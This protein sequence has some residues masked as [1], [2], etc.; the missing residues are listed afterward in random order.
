MSRTLLVTGAAGFI[1][2]CFTELAISQGHKVIALDALTYAGQ[3]SNLAH[4]EDSNL[5]EFVHGN[6]CSA[7]LVEELF[8]TYRPDAV[9]NLAA[10]SHVDRS[11]N[12]PAD[13]IETNIKGTF[14]LLD[15]SLSYWKSLSSDH[16]SFFRYVQVSTDEV[17][18]FLGSE[19][20]F[21][22][23]S[24]MAPNSPYSASKASGDMLV[25]AWNK[26]YGLP[27][28][29]TNSSNNYG[30]RQH[31]EKLIPH[32]I[33]CALRGHPL[34]IFGDGHQSRDW[35]HVEDNC[36]GILLALEK[37]RVGATYCFGGDA[38]KANMD[39]VTEICHALDQ[40]RPRSD[41]KLHESAIQHVIDRPGHDR[42][43]SIDDRF[44]QN[45]LGF[46]RNHDFESGL[47]VTI[48]W[49]LDHPEW[50]EPI[51]QSFHLSQRQ[52]LV[53]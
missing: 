42:R 34:P 21:N 48:Q 40:L 10:E 44:A 47:R 39:V 43:Y 51:L 27:T 17:Y 49:Y 26:T 36:Q 23:T 24:P 12:V 4:L 20:K 8:K 1:G 35:I 31:P 38:E 3:R 2:S 19:G 33:L 9:I 53:K 41:G 6:I 22:E 25:R 45:E 30:P 7:R 15:T 32:M 52:G 18:G 46:T 37:G 13:F 5:F 50:W 29:V 16:A 11:I 28:I 14:T